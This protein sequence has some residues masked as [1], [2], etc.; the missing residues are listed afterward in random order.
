ME[1]IKTTKPSAIIVLADKDHQILIEILD[2][3]ANGAAQK[4]QELNKHVA[5]IMLK[6][7]KDELQPSK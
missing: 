7:L 6:I 4:D 5:R 2:N 1:Q 3:Y